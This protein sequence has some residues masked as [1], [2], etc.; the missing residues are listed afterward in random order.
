MHFCHPFQSDKRHVELLNG[1]DPKKWVLN[2]GSCV[3]I[4]AH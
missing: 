1:H 3:G 2:P 4:S